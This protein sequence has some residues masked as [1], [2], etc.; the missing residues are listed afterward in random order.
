MNRAIIIVLTVLMLTPSAARADRSKSKLTSGVNPLLAAV[1]YPLGNRVMLPRQFG[2]IEVEGLE[3]LPKDG[4]VILAPTHRSRWDAPLVAS[5][6][7]RRIKRKD[8]RFMT[9]KDQASGLQGALVR[10]L[11]G[12]PVDVRKPSRETYSHTVDLLAQQRKLVIFP[13]GKINRDGKLSKL[14]PGVARMALKAAEKAPG[15]DVAIVPVGITY[16]H[17]NQPRGTKV[18]LSF[19]KPLKTSTYAATPKKERPEQITRD[20]DTALRRLTAPRKVKWARDTR[21]AKEIASGQPGVRAVKNVRWGFTEGKRREDWKPKFRDASIPTSGVKDVYY[22]REPFPPESIAS[23]GM[24]A[25]SF[26]RGNRMAARDGSGKKAQGLVVSMEARLKEGQPY[27]LLKG[28]GKNFGV[29][30]QLGTWRDNVQKATRRQGHR[31]ERHKLKLTQEQKDNLLKVAVDAAVKD[32][33]GEFYHT[34]RN[35]CYG[36]VVRLINK[37]VPRKQRIRK[38]LVPGVL[39]NPAAV[40]PNMGPRALAS[41]GLI[42]LKARQT[43][44]ANPRLAPKPVLKPRPRRGL[45]S[46]I[47][48]T[49]HRLAA[50]GRR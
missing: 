48:S 18:R 4:A 15:K 17:P 40:A 50:R 20:L 1:A 38:W 37:V 49:R 24:L 32:R 47:A 25:F 10:N 19:G 27:N 21:P 28:F 16:S 6:A 14:K 26:N 44:R 13:E 12:F 9:R 8:L 2:K 35:S 22:V 30:Y 42:N 7:S 3:N 46:R 36:N 5:V 43:I 45:K 11:G 33:A 23:H 41:K 31:L 34:T 29:V 39:E